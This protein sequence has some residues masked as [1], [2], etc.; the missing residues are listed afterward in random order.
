MTA[1]LT[2]CHTIEGKIRTHNGGVEIDLG[3]A[4]SLELSTRTHNGG[5]RCKLPLKDGCVSRHRLSGTIGEGGG[6]LDVV[7]HNGGIRI[8][9]K[10]RESTASAH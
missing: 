4:A 9:K 1:D 7:T 2:A 10:E 3:E 6:K 5:I 8:N